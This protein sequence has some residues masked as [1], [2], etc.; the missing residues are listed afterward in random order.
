MRYTQLNYLLMIVLLTPGAFSRTRKSG[1]PALTVP[2][3]AIRLGRV[4]TV[5]AD[6]FQAT[7]CHRSV[8]AV[9]PFAVGTCPK[10]HNHGHTKPSPPLA[11]GL[12]P[13]ATQG[14]AR[15]ATGHG[16]QANPLLKSKQQGCELSRMVQKAMTPR[17]PR[18]GLGFAG[19]SRGGSP[20]SRGS[21]SNSVARQRA[22]P[23]SQKLKA[24]SFAG[25][26]HRR[27]IAASCCHGWAGIDLRG[28]CLLKDVH[29][30]SDCG[31]FGQGPGFALK[32]S[33]VQTRFAPLAA[34]SDFTLDRA[35]IASTVNAPH[36]LVPLRPIAD[37]STIRVQLP[38]ESGGFAA[39]LEKQLSRF[40]EPLIPIGF[41]LLRK[42]SDPKIALLIITLYDRQYRLSKNLTR[43]IIETWQAEGFAGFLVQEQGEMM[44]GA[45]KW[46][47]CLP[48]VGDPILKAKSAIDALID[49]AAKLERQATKKRSEAYCA[50]LALEASIK[51]SHWTPEEIA[52]A[53]KKAGD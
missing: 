22:W 53:K 48:E 45:M 23:E 27:L 14:A 16:G 38:F 13:T 8:R 1:C 51:K 52:A 4:A 46:V 9:M 39:R 37:D 3:A 24:G 19:R 50:A 11:A 26:K 17:S 28:G 29:I 42:Q 25:A 33:P 35:E 43:T 41:S 34:A 18:Q 47:A 44:S 20:W 30:A 7:T 6:T 49:E 21:G 15:P 2:G 32:S 31:L 40:P 36:A 12:N 5:L 10:G